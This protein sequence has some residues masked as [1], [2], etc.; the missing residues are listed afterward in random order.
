MVSN[1]PEVID[2]LLANNQAL[3]AL[4]VIAILE[5][6]TQHICRD[7]AATVAV[8]CQRVQAATQLQLLADA[9][10]IL[11]SLMQVSVT[12][13]CRWY[14]LGCCCCCWYDTVCK[15]GLYMYHGIST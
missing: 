8:R 3:L 15:W 13:M 7:V 1:L 10:A 6:L 4:P 11:A 14:Y 9:A 2:I 12:T 5:W